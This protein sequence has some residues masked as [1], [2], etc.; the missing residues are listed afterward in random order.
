MSLRLAIALILI[1]AGPAQ[2]GPASLPESTMRT[3][4]D[5]AFLVLKDKQLAGRAHRAER[6]ASL[7][8]VADRAFD[9]GEMARSSLGAAWRGLTP[10][11]RTRF[12]EVFKD[13]LAGEY[14]D[15]IDRFQGTETVTVDGSTPQGEEVVVHSTL[16]TASRDRVPI[17]YRM[18]AQ[19]ERWMVVDLS[20]EGVSLVNHF[21]RT[22]R[23]ALVNMT[24][25]QLIERLRRQLPAGR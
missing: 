16:T 19:A 25:D 14:I 23:D 7:R 13:V 24:V 1:A 9:W 18:R 12:V 22:F 6:V 10:D 20:I 21:R 8:R 17:D 15:D 5:A 2:A 4:V 3:T 11:Q